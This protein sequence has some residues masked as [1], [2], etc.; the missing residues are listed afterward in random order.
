MKGNI[1]FIQSDNFTIQF[2]LLNY[3][4]TYPQPVKHHDKCAHKTTTIRVDQWN[5]T[6]T[7]MWVE[8]STSLL[9]G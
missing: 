5:S 4:S 7:S 1:F 8:P 3:E 2:F 6:T 9:R